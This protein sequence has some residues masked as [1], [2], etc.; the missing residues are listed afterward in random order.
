MSVLQE[1]FIWA[2]ALPPWEVDGLSRLLS[3]P[4]LTT[5]D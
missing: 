1:I 3:K 4:S 2:K 5:V